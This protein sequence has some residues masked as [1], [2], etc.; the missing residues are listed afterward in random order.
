MS[1]QETITIRVDRC[2]GC[3]SCELACAVAHSA[4]GSLEKAVESGEKPGYRVNVEACGPSAVPVH[5]NHCED[6]ACVM[7]CPTG[8]VHRNEKTGHVVVDQERCIGCK[9]CVQACPFGVIVTDPNGKGVLKCDMCAARLAKGEE[10]AC[11][12]AC[13]TQALVFG[14]EE[15]MVREKRKRTAEKMVMAREEA[16]RQ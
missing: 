16:D 14:S 11:I 1:K 13:P 4:S 2:V 9:M 5:C 12:E 7:A 3:R 10:P 15:D 8:A 6:A